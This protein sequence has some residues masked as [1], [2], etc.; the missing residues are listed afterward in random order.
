MNQVSQCLLSIEN[1]VFSYQSACCLMGLYKS[2]QPT[3]LLNLQPIHMTRYVLVSLSLN[4]TQ[5]V[6]CRVEARV[7]TYRQNSQ[8]GTVG[9]FLFNAVYFRRSLTYTL[10]LTNDLLD[11]GQ[12]RTK[13]HLRKAKPNSALKTVFSPRLATVYQVVG[14]SKSTIWT[15]AKINCVCK[16]ALNVCPILWVFPSVRAL[17]IRIP[18]CI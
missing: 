8:A 6:Y 16:A 5:P 18:F 14:Y 10:G 12:P 17:N 1:N 15:L 9:R 11:G 2:I 13:P 4:V 7:Q 3:N